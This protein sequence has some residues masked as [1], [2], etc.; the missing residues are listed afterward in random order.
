MF[1]QNNPGGSTAQFR[2]VWLAGP[3]QREYGA[4]IIHRMGGV[5]EPN[6]M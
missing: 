1:L 4:A 6:I 2:R 3:V 5:D